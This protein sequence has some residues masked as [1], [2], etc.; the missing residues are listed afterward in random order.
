MRIV[1]RQNGN[2]RA[3][4]A[5]SQQQNTLLK[6]NGTLAAAGLEEVFCTVAPA[7]FVPCT[8]NG[9]KV[10][11]GLSFLDRARTLELDWQ[12]RVKGVTSE[13]ENDKITI[14]LMVCDHWE[15]ELNIQIAVL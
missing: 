2:A 1:E 4:S 13:M 15:L 8:G 7:G 14:H 10:D 11:L 9:I 12:G 3:E 6:S 5:A